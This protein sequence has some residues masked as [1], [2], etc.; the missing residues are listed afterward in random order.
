ME[1]THT[2]QP[3]HAGPHPMGFIVPL[4]VFPLA[5]GLMRKMAHHHMSMHNMQP[6]AEWQ[7]GVPPIFAEMH[8]RAHAA[9][10]GGEVHSA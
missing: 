8:R 2:H 9:E 6:H 7:N 3:C 1:H 5:I 4:L 10:A